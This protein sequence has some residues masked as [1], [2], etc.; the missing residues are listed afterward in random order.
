MRF[1][2]FLLILSTPLLAQPKLDDT[3]PTAISSKGGQLTL[4]GTGLK[5]PLSLWSTSQSS[6]IFS[7]TASTSATTARA[8][9]QFQ[10]ISEPFIA[11]RLATTSG[12]SNPLLIAIDDLPT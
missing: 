4:H 6:T 5:A 9:L 12:I 2:F 3:S 10:Q 8:T 11:I 7:N 1:V